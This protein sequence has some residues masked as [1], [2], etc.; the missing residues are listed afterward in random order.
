MA[1]ELQSDKN[2]LVNFAIKHEKSGQKLIKKICT[3]ISFVKFNIFQNLTNRFARR[4]NFWIPW[5]K[6]VKKCIYTY[7]P[8]RFS[9]WDMWLL[10]MSI[11]TDLEPKNDFI[12]KMWISQKICLKSIKVI[13]E[14]VFKIRFYLLGSHFRTI[15]WILIFF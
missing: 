11:Y 5:L 14:K 15:R 6:M 12:A 10:S 1:S 2:F 9:F 13:D 8:N 7:I 3:Y 4:L